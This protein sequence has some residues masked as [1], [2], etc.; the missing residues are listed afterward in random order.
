VNAQVDL[1]RETQQH[2]RTHLYVVA[3]LTAHV[4]ALDDQITR[5]LLQ[6]EFHA[7]QLG[8]ISGRSLDLDDCHIAV[9]SLDV[10]AATK[11]RHI[12]ARSGWK[13]EASIDLIALF[14][15]S[16]PNGCCTQEKR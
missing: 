7:I 9:D 5:R 6:N 16:R 2:P 8:T 4:S 15:N 13:S 12:N 1:A 14:I 10:D 11:R 3:T